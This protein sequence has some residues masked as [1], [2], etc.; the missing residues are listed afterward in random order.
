[1]FEE[2]INRVRSSVDEGVSC[3]GAQLCIYFEEQLVVS[4]AFG[5]R[6]DGLMSA[7]TAHN[8]YCLSKPLLSIALLGLLDSHGINPN[9]RVKTCLPELELRPDTTFLQ[10][11]NHE[12][13][14]ALPN[15]TIYRMTRPALRQQLVAEG[16]LKQSG[17][18]EYSELLA[19]IVIER[20]IE[21]LSGLESAAYLY[22][23]IT[24]PHGIDV[25]LEPNRGLSMLAHGR[26]SV[27]VG[28]LPTERSWMLSE[29]LPQALQDLRP[30]L[31]CV[32]SMASA[33]KFFNLLQSCLR[34]ETIDGFPSPSFLRRVARD[35]GPQFND[36]R[37]RRP[38]Q[39]TAGLMLPYVCGIA[40]AASEAAVGQTAGVTCAA[41]I[42][43]P[44]L[45]IAATVLFN[46]AVM[47]G[48]VMELE[49]KSV[50]NAIVRVVDS[51]AARTVHQKWKS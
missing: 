39:F 30:A 10:L 31:G 17:M 47:D 34:G 11:L 16:L 12:A 49:R 8:T 5:S 20:A 19:G 22:E 43:D 32:W 33:C 44:K 18:P 15:A 14:L 25:A 4:E 24:D 27:P 48:Q 13:G 7:E 29:L 9:A 28:G 2:A 1:M 51:A 42:A 40:T 21:S 26:L 36:A 3:V 41:A 46:G 38:L 6:V 37:A 45:A 23:T 35:P 50:L